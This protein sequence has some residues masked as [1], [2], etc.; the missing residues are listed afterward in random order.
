MVPPTCVCRL[1]VISDQVL[2]LVIRFHL[3]QSLLYIE[4][5]TGE[6]KAKKHRTYQLSSESLERM[7]GIA[8]RTQAEVLWMWWEKLLPQ[9]NLLS[10]QQASV[11]PQLVEQWQQ[12]LT[13]AHQAVTEVF[14]QW[15]SID[16]G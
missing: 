2:V 14:D 13:N 11:D 4:D 8:K 16:R 10:R 6:T 1:L 12:R 9:R 5:R 7:E 15:R 3:S